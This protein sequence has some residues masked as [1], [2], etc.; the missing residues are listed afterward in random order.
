MRAKKES[1]SVMEAEAIQKNAVSPKNR[2]SRGNENI[3]GG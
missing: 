3:I 1:N 2:R